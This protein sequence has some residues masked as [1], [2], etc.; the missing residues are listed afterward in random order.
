MDMDDDKSVTTRLYGTAEQAGQP[1]RLE[2]GRLVVEIVNGEV[3]SISWDGIEAICGVAYPIRDVDWGTAPVRTRMESV[4]PT[5]DG[6]RYSTNFAAGDFAGSFVCDARREGDVRL[7]LSLTAKADTRVCRA[8][9]VVLHPLDVAGAP[10][11]VL[12]PDASVDETI[13]PGLISPTQPAMDIAGLDWVSHGIA[14]GMRFAGDR[15]EMEDQRNWSDASYKTFCRPLL[16]PYPFGIAAGEAIDQAITI[17]FAGSG[18]APAEGRRGA[19]RPG[20][21][22][23]SL[24]PEFGLALD[25]SWPM[26][27]GF[28]PAAAI[29][30]PPPRW[31][32]RVDLACNTDLAWLA[33]N[34][35]PLR[36]SPFDL[37]VIVDGEPPL[38]ERQLELA[39]DTLTGLGL[40]PEHLMVL[41]RAYMRCIQT[42][43]AAPAGATPAGAIEAARRVFPTQRLGA[44]MLTNFTE[45][46]RCPPT[47]DFDYV[48]HSLTP[49]VHAADDRSVMRALDTLEPIFDTLGTHARERPYRL[50]LASIGMRT[51]PYGRDVMDNPTGVRLAMAQLDPRQMGLFGAAWMVGVAAATMGSRIEFIAL[52]A[53]YGP[54]GLASTARGGG[55]SVLN[56]AYHAFRALAG[57]SGRPRLAIE[58]PVGLR[59]VAAEGDEGSQAV[60]ANC[61]NSAIRLDTAQGAAGLVLDTASMPAAV[62][63]RYWLETAPRHD[64]PL[65]LGPYSVAHLKW[66]RVST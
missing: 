56:P 52:A 34:A 19:V 37:E 55:I 25:P 14:V 15:F 5:V 65:T 24:M 57:L 46:N 23:G 16:L 49:L 62:V 2:A 3:S 38:L 8:G 18:T 61:T 54:F 30:Q 7:S 42:W 28:G 10:L 35:H 44:G 13:F 20:G 6:V 40:V 12:H 11:R 51:N 36:A 21:V 31:L 33:M 39:L 27:G 1:V 53:P 45:L 32:A 64:G 47:G 26:A 59:G 63:D 22:D 17:R 9:F 48:T 43:E 50:G 29:L 4:E 60:I 66:G 58:L 41:P